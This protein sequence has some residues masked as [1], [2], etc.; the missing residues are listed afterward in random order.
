MAPLVTLTL[1]TVMLGMVEGKKQPGRCTEKWIDDILM[2]C[3]QDI[4]E[5][6]TMT[7]YKWRTF[8]ASLYGSC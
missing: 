6:T 1:K 7:E 8:V 3:G 5:V 2:W 4:K